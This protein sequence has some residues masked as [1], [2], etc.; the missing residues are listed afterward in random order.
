MQKCTNFTL[1]QSSLT[2]TYFNAAN[3]LFVMYVLTAL[4]SG[5]Y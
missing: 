3:Y 4:C 5:P 1:D 2:C